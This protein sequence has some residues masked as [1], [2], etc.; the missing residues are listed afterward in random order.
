MYYGNSMYLEKQR[1]R[2]EAAIIMLLNAMVKCRTTQ[3][4]GARQRQYC[5]RAIKILTLLGADITVY[6]RKTEKLFQE[7]LGNYAVS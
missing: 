2:G 7:E 3:N 1:D 6:D 4:R 5:P